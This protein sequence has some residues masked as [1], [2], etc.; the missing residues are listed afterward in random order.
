MEGTMA[1]LS[2]GEIESGLEGLDGWSR[3]GEA[4][5]KEFDRGDFMGSVGLVDEIAPVAEEM[6]HHPDLAI[7]WDTVSVTITTHSEGGLTASD[8]ELARRIDDLA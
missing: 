4:I 8:F 2:E 7:S 6:G 5:A 1:R 3:D